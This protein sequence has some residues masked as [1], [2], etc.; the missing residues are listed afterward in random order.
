MILTL[1]Y[2]AYQ[3]NNFSVDNIFQD[4]T[5][6]IDSTFVHSISDEISIVT[7]VP[8]NCLKTVQKKGFSILY[9][10]IGSNGIQTPH[11]VIKQIEVHFYEIPNDFED[12]V[13]HLLGLYG[14]KAIKYKIW[15][16]EFI[17]DAPESPSSTPQL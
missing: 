6:E 14:E 8:L 9:R 3:K 2:Q 4:I 16:E 13:D 17:G 12:V 1:T 5:S 11:F 10:D 15:H 7:P